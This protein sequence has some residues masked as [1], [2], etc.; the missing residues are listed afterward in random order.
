MDLSQLEAFVSV[1]T[2]GGFTRA[3]QQLHRTQ[4]AVSR[5]VQLLE[6]SLGT[7]LFARRGREIRLTAEG[8]AFLPYAQQA[9]AA[10][11]DGVCAL[12][13]TADSPR[14]LLPFAIA[15]VG[16]LADAYFTEVLRTFRDRHP[17]V[18]VRLRTATSREVSELVLRG[19]ADLGVRYF[20][21]ER[22][23][24]AN[25]PLGIER[26]ML[27]A[28]ERHPLAGQG[29]VDL[30]ELRNDH[31]LSF[32]FDTRSPDSFGHLL[33][34]SLLEVGVS[35]PKLTI[36]DSLTAQKRLVEA[37]YGIAFL[38]PS[39]CREEL[40]RGT[41]RRLDVSLRPSQPVVAVRRRT[42]FERRYGAD[43]LRLMADALPSM[44][45]P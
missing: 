20:S 21:D 34:R 11:R 17:G 30:A 15:V 39:A 27:V 45:A 22:P 26:L 31:W 43:F 24:I 37:G 23:Q 28:P 16:T 6:K 42:G 36:V 44:T 29:H 40:A 25:T 41:L 2:L 4:P 9:L 33:Q 14:H 35:D 18:D 7:P 19:E 10:I 3:S 8:R 5:R 1:A 38:P 32:P 13:E 12:D